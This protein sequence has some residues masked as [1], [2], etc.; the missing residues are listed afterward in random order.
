MPK[1]LK[2]EKGFHAC[3][4]CGLDHSWEYDYCSESCW[5]DSQ[6]YLD[7]EEELMKVMRYLPSKKWIILE[8]IIDDEYLPVLEIQIRKLK[9]EH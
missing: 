9:N 5:V 6:D 8:D 3:S 4:S 7:K 2:C 1:C